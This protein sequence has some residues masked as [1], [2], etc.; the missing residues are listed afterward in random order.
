[1][2]KKLY[3][4][5]ISIT[6]LTPITKFMAHLPLALHGG[7]PG[8][9]L[10]ICFGMGTTYR[11]LLS[12]G[13]NTTAVELVPGVIKVF[14]YFHGDAASVMKDTNGHVVIDDG[15]R[16]LLRG[17]KKYDVITVDP[18]PPVEAAG[19]SLLYSEEFYALVNEHLNPGGM[20][21]QWVP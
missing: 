1:M 12:W 17:K 15:R 20:F 2:R 7:R 6:M 8:S 10:V 9:A 5:G 19:S 13:V 21:Q 11:S 4:N 14:G 16:F 3:V 18:P